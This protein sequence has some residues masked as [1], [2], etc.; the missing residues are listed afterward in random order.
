MKTDASFEGLGAVLSQ[1][2]EGRLH[3]V[4]FVSRGLRR[5]ERIM[6][7]YSSWKLELLAQKWAV[8]E[9]F[10]NYYQRTSCGAD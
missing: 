1:E 7:N 5:S 8:T 9:Q 10:K 2:Y 4:A 6:T 3:P